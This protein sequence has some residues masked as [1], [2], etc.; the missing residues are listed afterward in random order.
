M[1]FL[2]TAH[3]H[4][5]FPH[6]LIEPFMRL[7]LLN[8]VI[9][10]A[11]L[12][13]CGGGSDA[14]A[15]AAAPAPA[16]ADVVDKY[17][18]TWSLCAQYSATSSV[19]VV[20]VNAKLSATTVNY[21]YNETDYATSTTCGGT[22]VPDYSEAGVATYA[23]TKTIGADTVDLISIAVATVGGVADAYAFKDVAI[24]KNGQMFLGNLAAALDA[25][26]YP[27]VLLSKPYIKQ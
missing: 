8:I 4:F 23:G 27:T 24:V 19:K 17:A 12:S 25:Q 11:I 15:A 1:I 20:I 5:W 26:S 2:L 22:G 7:K 9:I 13:A 3:L 18:G 10:S 6:F 16:A 21:A 14:P